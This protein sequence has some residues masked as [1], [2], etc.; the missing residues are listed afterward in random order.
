MRQNRCGIKSAPRTALCITKDE[1]KKSNYNKL[2]KKIRF[3]ISNK[4]AENFVDR[5][6]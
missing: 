4:K 2:V 1:W 3:N 5:E 6:D